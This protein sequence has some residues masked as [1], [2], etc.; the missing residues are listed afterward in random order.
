[1]ADGVFPVASNGRFT[2]GN[3]GNRDFSADGYC[4]LRLLLFRKDMA[5]VSA[6]PIPFSLKPE[7]LNQEETET[8]NQ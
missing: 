1:V 3:R 2:G 8:S 7:T 5:E 4:S 6:L